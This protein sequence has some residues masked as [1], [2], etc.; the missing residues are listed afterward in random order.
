MDGLIVLFGAVFIMAFLFIVPLLGVLFGALIGFVVSC[1]PFA[2]AWV[3]H[4]LGLLGVNV[5][6]SDL[7][8]LGATLGF[9]GGFFKSVNSN[10]NSSK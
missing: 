4:G 8:S 5:S 7:V 1:V 6:P 10:S 3:I 9:V 2:A